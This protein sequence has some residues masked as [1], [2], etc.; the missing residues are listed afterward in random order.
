MNAPRTYN[1]W[2]R[3]ADESPQAPHSTPR[4]RPLSRSYLSDPNPAQT[5]RIH[6]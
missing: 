1:H 6:G 3:V 2:T 4:R 5:F